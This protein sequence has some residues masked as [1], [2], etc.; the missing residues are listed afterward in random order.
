MFFTELESRA[1]IIGQSI[2]ASQL[3]GNFLL[4]LA[5]SRSRE[6]DGR[7]YKIYIKSVLLATF[8]Y[9]LFNPCLSAQFSELQ[10]NSV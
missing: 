5:L 8:A 10:S 7:I 3:A 2:Q 6:P 9:I 1:G 4:W